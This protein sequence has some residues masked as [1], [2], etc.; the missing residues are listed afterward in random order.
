VLGEVGF[1][2]V[3]VVSRFDCFRGTS[4]EKTA[5]KFGVRGVNVSGRKT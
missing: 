2:D 3:K 1:R 5:Q 4:K